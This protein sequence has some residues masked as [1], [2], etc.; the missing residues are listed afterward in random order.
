M[1]KLSSKIWEA[2]NLEEKLNIKHAIAMINAEMARKDVS[3]Q[4]DK[5]VNN[6][7][8]YQLTMELNV[9]FFFERFLK[10]LLEFKM[11]IMCDN[12]SLKNILKWT[13]GK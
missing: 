9:N 12:L 7:Y 1:G 11:Y 10:I 13:E 3:W 6:S 8:F 2:L 4:P 5:L